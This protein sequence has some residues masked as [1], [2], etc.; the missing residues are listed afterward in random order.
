MTARERQSERG[1]EQSIDEAQVSCAGVCV[2]E[3]VLF[4]WE[5]MIVAVVVV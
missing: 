5:R 3:A 2:L 4:A 1:W